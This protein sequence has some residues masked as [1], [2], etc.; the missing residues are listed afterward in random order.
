MYKEYPCK[1]FLIVF[2]IIFLS[3]K[4]NQARPCMFK[5]KA[6]DLYR[7]VILII[8]R[9]CKNP[10]FTPPGPRRQPRE[11]NPSSCRS[12]GHV[13]V[14]G[15]GLCHHPGLHHQPCVRCV[16][17]PARQNHQVASPCSQVD[18]HSNRPNCNPLHYHSHRQVG[19]NPVC[20][21]VRF[22]V[23]I[24]EQSGSDQLSTLFFMDI[25]KFCFF[26]FLRDFRSLAFLLM[27]H[28]IFYFLMY[29][30]P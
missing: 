1:L 26:V 5:L 28:C 19:T 21:Y 29:Y 23:E 4:Y 3:H 15:P 2:L 9:M 7:G 25:V 22:Q 20:P 6:E 12:G 10:P 17:L 27:F 8:L 24:A 30:C 11:N 13:C 16:A 18:H 14:A